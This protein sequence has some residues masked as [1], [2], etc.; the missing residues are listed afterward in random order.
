MSF[1][2]GLNSLHTKRALIGKSKKGFIKVNFPALSFNR[3]IRFLFSQVIRHPD[4][5]PSSGVF[6]WSHHE[7]TVIIDQKI[8]FVGGIDLCFGRWDDEYMR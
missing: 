8:A 2:M 1:A 6:L 4:H 5:Y 7:K 3:E